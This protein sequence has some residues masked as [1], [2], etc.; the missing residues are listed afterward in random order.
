VQR[1]GVRGSRLGGT[2]AWQ[3]KEKLVVKWPYLISL[4]SVARRSFL[5]HRA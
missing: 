4:L 1:W 5:H 3:G 2:V